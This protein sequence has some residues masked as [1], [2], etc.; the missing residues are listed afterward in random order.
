MRNDR[1]STAVGHRTGDIKKG[2]QRPRIAR[3]TRKRNV[4]SRRGVSECQIEFR[5]RW[6]GH[7]KYK[8][9]RST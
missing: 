3:P 4:A 5:I 8:H 1:A 6:W 7:R 2:R 9:L